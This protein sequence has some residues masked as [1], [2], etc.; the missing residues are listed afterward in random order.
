MS[1]EKYIGREN[2]IFEV[3]QDFIEKDLD[4]I[5]IGGYAISSF[6][7]RFSVDADV[8]IKKEDLEKFADLLKQKN[9]KKTISKELN[10]LYATEF[11]RYE[12]KEELTVSFDLL[13]NGMGIRQTD[14]S[15]SFDAIYEDSSKRIIKGI[16]KEI[17]VRIPSKELLIALKL[18]AG[19][20]TDFRDIVAL[21]RGI[22]VDKIKEFLKVVDKKILKQNINYLLSL[23]DK[24]EFMDSFKGVFMEK[25]FDIDL[26]TIRKLK[27]II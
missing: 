21:S 16:E 22:D 19:R 4:F 3:L 10:N 2:T 24:K 7:H 12:K 13:I 15:M 17:K 14:S 11:I 25:K 27:K 20:L 23:I 1:F 5:L 8:V 18:Q 9:F 26:E 6:K